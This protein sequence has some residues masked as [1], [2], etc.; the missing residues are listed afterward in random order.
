MMGDKLI[1]IMAGG[2]GGHVFPGLA[3]A[4]TL[5][6]LGA[7]VQWLGTRKGIEASLVPAADI[8]ISYLHVSGVRGKGIW[9]LLKAPFQITK[10]LLEAIQVV[11]QVSPHCV[12]GMGGFASGP[13][14]I[15]AWLLGKPLVIHEQNAVAGTTN[16]ILARF[17]KRIMAA[18][19]GAF[20]TGTKAEQTGNPVRSDIAQLPEPK[21]EDYLQ[22]RALKVLVLGGS[23]GAKAIN[24]VM[25]EL[26]CLMDKGQRIELWHQVGKVHIGDMQGVYQAQNMDARVEAFIDDMPMAYGWADLVICRAGALTVSELTA[27]GKAAILIPYPHAIDDHQTKNAQWLVSNGAGIV[28]D[29]S[30][31]TAESLYGHLQPIIQ[32]RRR[33]FDM[34]CNARKLATPD[35]A[36]HVANACLEVAL[37]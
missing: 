19:P 33:L 29:Q 24:Q 27:A 18:F 21:L 37:D 9:S 25:P 36:L 32:D 3:T 28:L 12:L 17:A 16:R 26:L 1:L 30:D 2:T 11:R 35:A 8:P 13:G 14:G 15:A 34:A 31:M 23:L 20:R 10:A 5:R 7:S 6:S 4:E 22:E